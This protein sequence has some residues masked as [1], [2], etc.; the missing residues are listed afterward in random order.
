MNSRNPLK[1]FVRRLGHMSTYYDSS[2]DLNRERDKMGEDFERELGHIRQ[3]GRMD[4][5]PTAILSYKNTGRLKTIRC[6]GFSL[7][8]KFPNNVLFARAESPVTVMVFWVTD[9]VVE[10]QD[11][12][13]VSAKLMGH[14]FTKLDAAWSFE[15]RTRLPNGRY[16]CD[17]VIT[18]KDTWSLQVANP[19]HHETSLDWKS[20]VGKG[21][22]LPLT[23]NFVAPKRR[24]RPP[25]NLVLHVT[26][27][28]H[29]I[30]T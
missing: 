26:L 21:M 8:D 29:C 17:K 11:N 14:S 4:I 25:R 10:Y 20:V 5:P 16:V 22:A 2:I 13:I 28:Q 23:S 30:P 9:M 24:S 15:L 12:L 1:T 18:S 6:E 3:H 7:T 19:F 27:L